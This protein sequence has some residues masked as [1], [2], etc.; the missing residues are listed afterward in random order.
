M[1]EK[2]RMR[3]KVMSIDAETEMTSC[4]PPAVLQVGVN[5]RFFAS[6]LLKFAWKRALV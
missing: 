1:L 2:P 3:M 4:D 6:G 5:T